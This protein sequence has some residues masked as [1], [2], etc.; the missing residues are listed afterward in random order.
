M[1]DAWRRKVTRF[2]K[3]RKKA[4]PVIRCGVREAWIQVVTAK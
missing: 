4:S 3:P 1:T 2:L